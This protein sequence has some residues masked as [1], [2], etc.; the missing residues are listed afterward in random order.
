MSELLNT[1]RRALLLSATDPEAAPNLD[2]PS[3]SS[4]FQ[5]LNSMSYWTLVGM[6]RE[7][8]CTIDELRA[9]QQGGSLMRRAELQMLRDAAEEVMLTI[10]RLPQPQREVLLLRIHGRS[11]KQIV[12]L[13]PG[14]VYFSILDDFKT[15]CRRLEYECGYALQVLAG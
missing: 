4:G 8:G 5:E 6:S 9:E 2:Y 13:T 1:V 12:K 3:T 11:W 15:A 7:L 10:L 14:R